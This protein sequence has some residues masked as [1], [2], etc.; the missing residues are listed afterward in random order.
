VCDGFIW[1]YLWDDLAPTVALTHWHYR[2]HGR[3]AA[4]VDPDRIDISAHADDLSAVRR[5][6]GNPPCVIIG[7]SMGCQVA[8]ENYRR[9]GFARS[10]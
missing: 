9:K 7:H 5:H 2:G 3:S 4:P 6:I 10:S 8:L 1:K